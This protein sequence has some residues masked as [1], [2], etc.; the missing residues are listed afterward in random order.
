VVAIVLCKKKHQIYKKWKKKG[1]A[2]KRKNTK[3]VIYFFCILRIFFS[4]YFKFR[5]TELY[6]NTSKHIF[7]L[8][9]NLRVF[10]FIFGVF[11]WI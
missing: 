9:E 7:F 1:K 8:F 3:K 5:N 10:S 11:E 6:R 2:K 4:F